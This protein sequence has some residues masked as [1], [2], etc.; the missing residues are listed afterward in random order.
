MAM[1]RS[2]PKEYIEKGYFIKADTIEELAQNC[3]INTAD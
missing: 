3:G 1:P 2:T